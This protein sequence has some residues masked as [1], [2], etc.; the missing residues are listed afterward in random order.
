MGNEASSNITFKKIIGHVDE[1]EI[2]NLA[3]EDLFNIL[4]TL[5]TMFEND[6]N[7]YE[8]LR[9]EDE[10]FIQEEIEREEKDDELKL[11]K[12]EEEKREHQKNM[13]SM[14]VLIDDNNNIKKH[15]NNDLS[16]RKSRRDEFKRRRS[17]NHKD[18]K[19]EQQ[20]D[21]NPYFDRLLTTRLYNLVTTTIHL[22]F[23]SQFDTIYLTNVK[24][25][26]YLSIYKYFIHLVH[27]QDFLQI[28]LNNALGP[29]CNMILGT[30]SKFD[31]Y[32]YI[33]ISILKYLSSQA[34]LRNFI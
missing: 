21:I 30:N 25:M 15:Q 23:H 14:N 9:Q 8:K 17:S 7:C 12:E 13:R 1:K 6:K 4:N 3:H 26:F 16:R 32:F 22:N 20:E 18:V 10:L 34:V 2:A 27:D 24:I 31:S 5:L 29:M 19:A 33:S 11:Q 28:L